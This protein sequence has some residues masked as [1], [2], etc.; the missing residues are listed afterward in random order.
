MSVIFENIHNYFAF[1]ARILHSTLIWEARENKRFQRR[2]SG[3]F[4][5]LSAWQ[6]TAVWKHTL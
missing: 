5:E 4:R 2:Y 1:S 3:R 6:A